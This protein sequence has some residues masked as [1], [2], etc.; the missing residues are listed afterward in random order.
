ME[1]AS[2]L[3]SEDDWSGEDVEEKVIF[4]NNQRISL[5]TQKQKEK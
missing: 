2:M 3:F 5:L 4:V 1:E